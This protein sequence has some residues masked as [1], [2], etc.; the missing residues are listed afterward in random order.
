MT[1]YSQNVFAYNLVT[2]TWK[3]NL[4][5]RVYVSFYEQGEGWDVPEQLFGGRV[6]Y[7]QN[8]T[9]NQCHKNPALDDILDQCVDE[10]VGTETSSEPFLCYTI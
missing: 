6:E 9:L 7:Y 3:G 4:T 5:F 8:Q 1:N 10:R 2:F